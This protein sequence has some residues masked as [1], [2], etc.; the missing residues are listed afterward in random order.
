MKS[1]VKI[2]SLVLVVLMVRASCEPEMRE[3]VTDAG[4]PSGIPLLTDPFELS[5][6]S[7][8]ASRILIAQYPDGS[9][10]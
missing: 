5:M 8:Q 10:K 6:Y 3:N 1:I 2:W 4:N 7:S 9:K